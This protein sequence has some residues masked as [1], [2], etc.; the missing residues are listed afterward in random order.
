MQISIHEVEDQVNITVVLCPNHILQP[1]NVLM[2]SQFLQK[3]DFT[4]SS[5]SICCVLEGIE[6]L[7]ECHN[8]LGALIY[9]LP[10]DSI[11]ALTC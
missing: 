2:T 5:L 10:D 1:N 6:V 9:R 8:L 11:S 7:L 3:Y 4:E